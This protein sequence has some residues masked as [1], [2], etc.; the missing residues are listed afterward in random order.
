MF[1]RMAMGLVLSMACLTGC[2]RPERAGP[3]ESPEQALDRLLIACVAGD[4]QAMLELTPQPY[5]ELCQTFLL[6][7]E[8]HDI[9]AKALDEKFGVA[10]TN[11]THGSAKRDLLGLR[12]A[13]VMNRTVLENGNVKL[14]V[15]ETF[16]DDKVSGKRRGSPARDSNYL[17]VNVDGAWQIAR[18]FEPW[19]QLAGGKAEKYFQRMPGGLDVE[20]AKVV[21]PKELDKLAAPS[22]WPKPIDRSVAEL[23]EEATKAKDLASAFARDIGGGKY[24]TRAEAQNAHRK[25]SGVIAELMATPNE[26]GQP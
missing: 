9:V 21:L 20:A 22:A 23:L 16:A 6:A 7:E 26:N 17:V 19:I 13:Q 1:Q 24:R 12:K 4:Q 8:S 3:T 25:A 10:K 11:R 5:R 2:A 14:M 18:P 15:R